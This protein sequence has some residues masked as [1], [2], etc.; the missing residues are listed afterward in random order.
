MMKVGIHQEDTTNLSVY[1]PNMPSDIYK[2]K[3][4][5]INEGK[6]IFSDHKERF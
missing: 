1:A 3:F 5:N 6:Q 4:D 2:E